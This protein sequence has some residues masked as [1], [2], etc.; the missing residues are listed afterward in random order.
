MKKLKFTMG[1]IVCFWTINVIQGKFGFHGNA[2]QGHKTERR[3]VLPANYLAIPC[4]GENVFKCSDESDLCIPEDKRCDGS[5]FQCPNSEDEQDCDSCKGEDMFYCS[6]KRKCI[7]AT[8]RCDYDNDCGDNE[9]E[10]GCP[11]DFRCDADDRCIRQNRVCDGWQS[12]S[13]GQDEKNCSESCSE[14][15]FH[16]VSDRMC[17]SM[18]KRCDS[19]IDC[20]S[21]EDEEKCQC[22]EGQ[23]KCGFPVQCIPESKKCD[24][25]NDCQDGSDEELFC[26]C[27]GYQCASGNCI[28]EEGRC[29]GN[30]YQCSNND[31]SLNCD[32][33]KEDAFYC[34]KDRKCIRASFRCDGDPGDCP[35]GKED[36]ENCPVDVIN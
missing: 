10:E 36:E 18:Y 31:D 12:C 30:G 9:D 8:W 2:K 6:T 7:S 11:C 22:E 34:P 15:A 13:D 3:M 28:S 32:S 20:P 26:P 4:D 23:H 33:C 19:E 16:C 17:V 14:Y 5:N 21:G 1:L 27:S 24:G 35:I 25:I 29:D